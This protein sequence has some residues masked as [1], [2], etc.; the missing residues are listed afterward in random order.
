MNN[1]PRALVLQGG[2]ALAAYEAGVFAAL[3]FWIKKNLTD[4]KE[5]IFDVIA[6][7]SGG[8][9]NAS[10]LVSHVLKKRKE[11][12][13]IINSWQGSTRKLFDFW[14]HISSTPDIRIWQPFYELLWAPVTDNKSWALVWDQK[15]K[16]NDH[17][18]T[19]EEARRYYSSKE[20]LYRGAPNVFSQKDKELDSKFFDNWFPP[21]NMRYRYGNT[22]LRESIRKYATFPIAKTDDVKDE[23][24]LLIVSTDVEKGKV[25]TFDSY[26]KIMKDIEDN[27]I[28]DDKGNPVLEWNT[29]YGDDEIV[30]MMYSEGI[31]VEHIMASSSVPIHYDYAL[32]PIEY[33]YAKT[34][35]EKLDAIKVAA[36]NNSKDYRKFWDG[37]ILSN[38]PLRELIQSHEDYYQNPDKDNNIPNLDV[39]IVD[40]WP[41]I[42]KYPVT[43]DNDGMKNRKNDLTYQDKTHYE[44]KV[45]NL[46]FDYIHLAKELIKFAK[47][48]GVSK[49]DIDKFLKSDTKSSQRKEENKKKYHDLVYGTF[50]ITE[51][52]R[53]D[54]KPDNE[55]SFKWTDF[56]RTTILNWINQGMKDTLEKVLPKKDSDRNKAIQEYIDFVEKEKENEQLTKEEAETLVEIVKNLKR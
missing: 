53:I 30:T 18:A 6:G 34:E 2:G 48:K 49:D 12:H 8:A 46:V 33:D 4:K 20:F 44:E 42:D 47:G 51:V 31:E 19:G 14:Y 39:Y 26:P 5:N 3:Y 16:T 41:F 29:E 22:E 35:S 21:V 28:T 50:E 9:I 52:I 17:V 38:T 10:I 24:R 13:D 40:I 25:V 7:T 27:M 43:N 56:S 32:V 55:I 37:G 15:H 23:P 11:G 36:V 1:S 45:A 54:R